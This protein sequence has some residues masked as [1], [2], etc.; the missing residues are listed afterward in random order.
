MI[1]IWKRCNLYAPVSISSCL[2]S[3]SPTSAL[4]QR[5]MKNSNWFA[6]ESKE[7]SCHRLSLIGGTKMW[8]VKRNGKPP[9]GIPLNTIRFPPYTSTRSSGM[10]TMFTINC[11]TDRAAISVYNNSFSL[12]KLNLVYHRSK[13]QELVLVQLTTQTFVDFGNFQWKAFLLE[14]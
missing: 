8:D 9:Y 11:S 1:N 7:D 5:I 12:T 14:T 2:V 10:V 4:G 6:S 3:S 13:T